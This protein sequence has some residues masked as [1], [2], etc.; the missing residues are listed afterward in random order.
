MDQDGRQWEGEG[1]T[2]LDMIIDYWIIS[3]LKGIGACVAIVVLVVV[4]MLAMAGVF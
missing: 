4:G 1:G 2:M 3:V